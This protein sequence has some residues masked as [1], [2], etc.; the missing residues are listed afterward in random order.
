M[1]A[2]S[3]GSNIVFAIPKQEEFQAMYVIIFF[4]KNISC[5]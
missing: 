5:P 1:H 4:I 2:S 3:I